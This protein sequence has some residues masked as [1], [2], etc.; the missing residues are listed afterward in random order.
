MA[1]PRIVLTLAL[2]CVG[3]VTV[4]GAINESTS[5]SVPDRAASHEDLPEHGQPSVAAPSITSAEDPS[6]TS[7]PPPPSPSLVPSPVVRVQAVT[8][9]ERVPHGVRTVKDPSLAKGKRVVR[10]RGVDGARTLT[11]QITIIDGTQTGRKLVRSALTRKP[12]T[13]VVAVGTKSTSRCD[14][15]Y[16]GCVPIASDVD[17]AGGGGNG[18]AYVTG[19]VKV[20]G[21]D[22]YDLDRD[23]DGWGCED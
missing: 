19:P 7:A 4:I 18:P 17:C 11:Y 13:E 12:V 15:N 16:G 2:L 20:I 3:G 9:T 10:T 14:P 23:N 22:I 6:T 8:E 21:V 5:T 1:F